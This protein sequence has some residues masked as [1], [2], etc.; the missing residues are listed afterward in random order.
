MNIRYKGQSLGSGGGGAQ[1]PAGLVCMWSGAAD[2]IPDGWALCDGQD[3]RPD[4]RDRFVLGA[5]N[6]YA[7]GETGGEAT[8]K[9]T[10]SEMPSHGHVQ[11]WPAGGTMGATGNTTLNIYGIQAINDL[12]SNVTKVAAITPGCSV[13]ARKT[14]SAKGATMCP[15]FAGA[16]TYTVNTNNN[17]RLLLE[18]FTAGN[19]AAHNNMP[20]YYALCYIIKL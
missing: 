5:G 18:T 14:V 8:H 9:L 15:D 20:P 7:A 1:I 16:N 17:V 2:N 19:S 12:S 10:A 13:G 4:L 11:T 3:G 6:T